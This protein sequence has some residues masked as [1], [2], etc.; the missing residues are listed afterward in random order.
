[1]K[2]SNEGLQN[3][4]KLG[5][6]CIDRPRT[7]S[8]TTFSEGS[9]SWVMILA[10]TKFNRRVDTPFVKKSSRKLQV[11]YLC[12]DDFSECSGKSG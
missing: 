3:H 12:V 9:V 7:R 10:H 5:I 4:A 2:D 11:L 6:G 1:M 8:L